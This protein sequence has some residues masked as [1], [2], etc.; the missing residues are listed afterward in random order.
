[1]LVFFNRGELTVK[2]KF[3]LRDE[4]KKNFDSYAVR[5]VISHQDLGIK[6][7]AEVSAEVKK[8]SAEAM[9]LKFYKSGKESTGNSVEQVQGSSAQK[10]EQVVAA[11]QSRS[12]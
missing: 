12:Q 6:T 11:R 8:H 7:V 9:V 3:N 2:I 10:G 1:V 5:D 4:L